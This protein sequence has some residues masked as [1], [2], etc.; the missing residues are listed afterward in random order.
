MSQKTQKTYDLFKLGKLQSDIFMTISL[1]FLFLKRHS[2]RAVSRSGE[3]GNREPSKFLGG[4]RIFLRCCEFL[5]GYIF[6]GF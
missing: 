6:T 5:R 2:I 1:F 4:A 3:G